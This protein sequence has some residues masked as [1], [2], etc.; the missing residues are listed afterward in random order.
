MSRVLL[1]ALPLVMFTPDADA[2]TPYQ[3][4]PQP[5]RGILDAPAPTTVLVSPTRDSVALVDTARYP[6]IAELAEPMLRLAGVRINPKTNGPARPPRVKSFRLQSLTNGTFRDT[7]TIPDETAF[8]TPFWSPDGKRVALMVTKPDSIWLWHATV[9]GGGMKELAGVRLNATIGDAAQWIDSNSLLVQLT[10]EGRGKPPEPPAAPPG[11]TIQESSGKAAPVRTY[12][13][14]LQDAHDEALFDHYC[15]SQLA[16]VSAKTGQVVPVGKPTVIL[17]A[18]PSP[19]KQ[20]ILVT[21][22][23][24][25]YSYLYPVSAFPRVVEVWDLTGKVVQTV[26]DLPLADRVPIEGVPT[27]PR[28]VRWVPTEPASLIWVEALDDGD[29]KKKVPHRDQA[30]GLASPFSGQPKPLF[31][32]EHRFSGVGFFED[33]TALVTD[34]DRDRKWARTVHVNLAQLDPSAPVVFD[35]SIQDRYNDPGTPFL[36]PLPNGQRVIHTAADG[37]LF[38]SGTGATPKGEFP[39][40]ALFDPKTKTSERLFQCRGGMYESVAAILDDTGKKLIVRRES[41][42]EPAN[43]FLRD[44]DKET[45]LTK[46]T[47]PFPDLR[48]VKKQ[49]VTTKRPDGVTISFTLYVPPGVK[50]GEK[51][52]TVFWAYPREFNTA[53][54]ASQVTGSPNRFTTLTGYS[55]LFLLTQGYA[56]M[57][58]VS[59]PVIGTPETANDT[60]VEQ[61]VMNAKAA[62]DKACEIGPIDRDR[63]GVGGHSYGAFMTANLLAHSDLFR[64][65][66]ARSGAYNRTLTP[67]GFQSERRTFWEAPDIYAKMSPFN[68]AHKIAE[69]LLLIH[70]EADNNA[71]TFPVQSERMYQAVRGN[72]GTVRLVMLPHESHGYSARES[73]E[74]VLAETIAWFDKHVKQ[75][76]PRLPK[77]TGEK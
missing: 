23:K 36:K 39:F 4:A 13:D 7:V 73:I 15:T 27:G 31:K 11:P 28:G 14:L 45:Q 58:D 66:V 40:L 8:A 50:D 33:G 68:A 46:N 74:H 44:G 18:D 63:I 52:P 26:A 67:F 41:P 61:L 24:K 65:G 19:D 55:H 3:R 60:F 76:K 10:P 72:G 29:P 43:Y 1:A 30:F 62:I 22:V 69:P 70:G 48:N 34:Y 37:K 77:G 57:D 54:T 2:Q 64:A 75:A 6:D 59:M 5:I 53:D 9:G 17:G 51:L 16:I 71:G 12:Q 32:T 35:R 49:L 42:T 56:V 20:F 38:L 25:P 21:R 47:D